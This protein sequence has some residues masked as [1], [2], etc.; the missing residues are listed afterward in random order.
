[1]IQNSPVIAQAKQPQDL[2]E[3]NLSDEEAAAAS[4]MAEDVGCSVPSETEFWGSEGRFRE[5][6]EHAPFGMSVNGLDGKFL[7]VNEAIL[8]M[9]GYSRDELL[10]TN[11]KRVTHPDDL[12]DSLRSVEELQ[13]QPGSSLETEKRYVHRNGT[14]VWA[15]TK[16]SMVPASGGKPA[17]WVAYLEDITERKRVEI[18]LQESEQRFQI[19]ADGSPSMMWVTNAQGGVQFINRAYREFIGVTT[20][21]MEGDK[22]RMVIHPE[23]AVEYV[24]SFLHAV[25][26][27]APFRAEGRV[28]RADGEWRWVASYGEPRLSAHGDFLGHVGISPDVTERKRTELALQGSE[29]KFRQIAENIREVFWMMSPTA[30]EML[31]ISPAYEHVWERSCESLYRN[32]MSWVEA[33]HPDDL[34]QAHVVFARQLQGEIVDSEYRI[35]TPDLQEKSIRDRAF[36]VRDKTGKLIRIVG[37]AEEITERKRYE[38]ELILA[39]EGADAASRWKSSFLANMSHEIRTPMNGIIGMTDLVLET[40]LDAEQTEYLKMVKTSANALLILIND[41]LDFS[42]MEAGKL[43]LDDVSFNLRKSLGEAVKMLGV[44]AQQKGLEFIFDVS[45]EVPAAVQGDAARLRQVVVNLAGNA[46]KFTESGEIEVKVQVQERSAEGVTLRF[47]VRDT[48]IGISLEKQQRIFDSFSQADSSTTRKYGG[49]GLGLTIAAQLVGL[50]GGK[51]WVE[52]A[53]GKGST[54]FSTIKVGYG[55]EASGS[56]A[57]DVAALAGVPVLIVDDN[58]ANRRILEDS[59]TRW[60]MKPTVVGNALAAMQALR[61]AHD[62]G[63]ELPVVLTD[64]HMPETDGFAFGEKIRE[65]PLL[66]GARIVILTS[67]SERGDAARCQKLRVAGYLSK[68]FDRL[69]LRDVLLRV[70]LGTPR[71]PAEASLA[72]PYA[73]KDKGKSLSFLVAEDNEVN[74]TLI[75][76]LLEKRGHRVVL[77]GNGQEALQELR[78]QTFDIVLMD[79]HMPEL[80]GFATTRIIREQEKTTGTHMA[81]VAL[82]ALAMQGDAER[83]VACG[84]DGYVSKPIKLDELFSVI[85]NVLA[86]LEAKAAGPARN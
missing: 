5:I 56:P 48:G 47:S 63:A 83:C 52:S 8:Q 36:P 12:E 10:S 54:F 70:V 77:A 31:Y 72:I 81:I 84:M 29:E 24:A 23:D 35:R 17:Y 64:A 18:A 61:K 41:I 27:H 11:W 58:A 65:D 13:E 57:I 49:T 51:I 44:A 28:R 45:P 22:W 1:M 30:D 14:V 85:E 42:K 7:H 21:Q 39:R 38:K 16:V 46:I 2:P 53:A 6:V 26:Q 71:E 79:G 9:L 62:A 80:D 60:S 34:E 67:G 55:V 20:E 66:S 86:S 69:E 4:T 73:V 50:M 25:Q 78:K 74:R 33:I 75:V 37:I 59:V 15:R 82:T 76:R 43:E 40:A 32:P 19:M 68:P 3:Q